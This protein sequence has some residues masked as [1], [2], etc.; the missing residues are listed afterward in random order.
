MKKL[1]IISIAACVAM[2]SMFSSCKKSSST[3]TTPTPTPT[4]TSSTPTPT[5]SNVD[6][7]LVSLKLDAITVAAGTPY[8]VTSEIGAASFF[9]ATGSNTSYVD[10]GTVSVNSNALDKQTNNTYTK[11]ATIGQTPSDLGYSTNNSNWSVGGAGSVPAFTHNDN[12]T[13][14]T[15][16]GTVPD[17][18]TR[19]AGVT[20]ALTG[21]VNAA[22]SVILFVVQGSTTIMRTV[23]G[24]A[25]SVSIAASDLSGL[26][27][28]TDKSAIIEVIPYHVSTSTQGSKTYAFIKEYAYV[29]TINIH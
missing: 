16:T 20:V 14:P 1:T 10:A 19:S 18:I 17:S 26:A 27:V 29:K 3:K 6:G 23:T 12:A 2:A 13:F 25:A 9:S 11:T 4:P 15:F 7:A 22:D 24:S 21:N 5:P 28:V 8:A